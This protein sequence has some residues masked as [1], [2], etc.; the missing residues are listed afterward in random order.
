MSIQQGHKHK[1]IVDRLRDIQNRKKL[2]KTEIDVTNQR[3]QACQQ[4][5]SSMGKQLE[6]GFFVTKAF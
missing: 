1:Q 6:V 3:K 2:H 4:D 5:I